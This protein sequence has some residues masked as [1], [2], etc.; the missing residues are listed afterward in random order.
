M[1]LTIGSQL[2]SDTSTAVQLI[3]VDVPQIL[4]ISMKARAGNVG[5][6]FVADDSSAKSSGMEITAGGREDWN[7]HPTTHKASTI[8]VWGNSSGDR[9][10]YVIVRG[11]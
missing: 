9:L 10:D 3:T 4:A 2:V 1:P 5:S 6:I 7:F 11:S 8:W